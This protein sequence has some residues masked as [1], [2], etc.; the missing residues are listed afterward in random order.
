MAGKIVDN[1]RFK[2]L[3]G[4][5]EEFETYNPILLHGELGL[6]EQSDGS[7][8][9]KIGNGV[10]PWVQLPYMNAGVRQ[11]TIRPE[12]MHLV[13]ELNDGTE[14]DAGSVAR[15]IDTTLSKT[16]NNPVTNSAISAK[17]NELITHINT[18]DSAGIE[19]IP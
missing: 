17:L 1:A 9:L 3:S 8:L 13:I 6:E 2:P 18:T 10:D 16:S 7:F 12:D 19:L 15:E 4:K 5:K 11:M 14:I